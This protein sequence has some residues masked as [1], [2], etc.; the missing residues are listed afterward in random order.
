MF[1]FKGFFL[2]LIFVKKPLRRPACLGKVLKR[3]SLWKALW[4]KLKKELGFRCRQV[5]Q[6]FSR[7]VA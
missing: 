6:S 2:K 3:F 7:F 4:L 5:G 1:S